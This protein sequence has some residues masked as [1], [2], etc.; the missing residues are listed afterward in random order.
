[1]EIQLIRHATLV[2]RWGDV[3]LLVDPMLS[4]AGTLDPIPNAPNQVRIPMIG[5]PFADDVLLEMVR[6][7]SGILVTHTHRD[8][9]DDRAADLIPKDT[10]LLCQPP[11]EEKLRNRGFADVTPV[12]DTLDWRGLRLTRTGGRHGTGEIGERM[13]PVSGFIIEAE[14]SPVVYVA[15]DTIWCDEVDAAIREHQPQVIVLNAGAAQFLVGD[16]ITMTTE[17]VMMVAAAAPDARIVAVHMDTIN[18]CLLTRAALRRAI[19]EEGLTDR[20]AVPDDG[21]THDVVSLRRR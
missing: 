10:P 1:M 20:V 7:V 6:S 8:H 13:G 12:T 14:G 4:P 16:P 5:L 9:W 17:D 19:E 18:H 15:G 3:S 11:D 21:A 2:L